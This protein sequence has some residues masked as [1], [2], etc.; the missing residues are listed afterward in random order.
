MAAAKAWGDMVVTFEKML[1][2]N[3]T[4]VKIPDICKRM[5]VSRI[6]LYEMM[7]KIGTVLNC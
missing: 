2:P 6:N 1:E 7:R 3:S 5:N 4:K